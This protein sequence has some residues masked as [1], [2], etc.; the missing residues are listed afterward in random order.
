[1]LKFAKRGNMEDLKDFLEPLDVEILNEDAGYTDGQ[2]GQ[3]IVAYT[4]DLPN[5]DGIDLVII[6]SGE[7]RGS[8]RAIGVIN[9]ANQIR[10]QLYR[11]H[12]WHDQIKLADLG[13]IKSGASLAD[14]YAAISTII[15]DL[16]GMGK[17]IIFLGGSHDLMLGMYK[18]YH[19]ARKQ[20]EATCI[21]AKIDLQGNSPFREENFLL[22]MLTGEPNYIRH[23]NHIGFQSYFVHPRMLE[24]MDK[25]RFDCFRV[26]IVRE[27]IEEMEPVIRNTHLLGFDIS[28]IR[29]SDAPSSRFSPNGFTGE[30]ACTLLQFAG[31]SPN[32]N[33][34]GLYGYYPFDDHHELTA[35]QI[36]QMIWYFIDGRNKRLQE[37]QLHERDN[38]IEYHT[39]FA[40]VDTLFL[41][42]K[43]TRRWW[44][45]MPDKKFISCSYNDYLNASRNQIP[46]RWLRFQERDV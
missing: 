28:A 36:A 15:A 16:V 26:G 1:M 21:D 5:L 44:M 3:H 46:E 17:T 33:C 14:T 34:L 6:G 2:I 9:S 25:L 27:N 30:E 32:L 13:N 18:S 38:F 45:Q 8:S 4:E 7:T 10:K 12:Y 20:I 42:S 35:L 22:E 24:T 37:S 29:N 23:Y 40:E 31:L 11:L 39:V 19:Q 41:Q 43:R